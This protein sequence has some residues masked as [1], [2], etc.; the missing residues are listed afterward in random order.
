MFERDGT[1][2]RRHAPATE[3]NREPLLEVLAPRVRGRVL[4]MASG[5][6]QHARYFTE[7]M[8]VIWQHT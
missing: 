4:E 8:P 5:K 3:R 7:R 2:G 1:S 6:G